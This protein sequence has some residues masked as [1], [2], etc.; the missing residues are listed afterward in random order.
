MDV[1]SSDEYYRLIDKT[2]EYNSMYKLYER[3]K[4]LY[5]KDKK[6]E[7]IENSIFKFKYELPK[8]LGKLKKKSIKDIYKYLK[9]KLDHK[10][11]KVSS[12]YNKNFK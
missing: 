5:K 1:F 9:K 11:K 7:N 4:K 6:L 10:H 3:C 12:M 8:N 2:V